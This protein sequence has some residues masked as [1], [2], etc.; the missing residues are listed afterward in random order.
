MAET[1]TKANR[2]AGSRTGVVTSKSA[3]KTI[4]VSVNFLV[5]HPTYGK[6]VRQRTK[7]AV[8]DPENTAKEGDNVEIVPCRRS[9]KSKSWRLSRVVR[10][11]DEPVQNANG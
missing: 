9:S 7:L 11:A 5:K 3:D 6:Y 2:I 4:Q 10:R 8:H 1:Q